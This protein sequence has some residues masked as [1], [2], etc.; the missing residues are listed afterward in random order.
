MKR[1]NLL[2]IASLLLFGA[3]LLVRRFA[4]PAAWC[5]AVI[6]IYA[7]KSGSKW[8]LLLPG[9]LCF[10][11]YAVEDLGLNY[12]SIRSGYSNS[13][14]GIGFCLT[15]AGFSLVAYGLRGERV[16]GRLISISDTDSNSLSLRNRVIYSLVGF[17]AIFAG[18]LELYARFIRA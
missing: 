9:S 1:S 2:G 15:G 14:E 8:W 5:S 6:G 4:F 10:F 17:V 12:G 7:A 3:A 11:A 13:R 16:P 18:F